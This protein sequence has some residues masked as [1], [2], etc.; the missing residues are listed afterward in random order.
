MNLIHYQAN[1]CISSSKWPIY[2]EALAEAFAEASA[3]TEPEALAFADAFAL[4][5]AEAEASACAEASAWAD[6]EPLIEPVAPGKEMLML[7]LHVSG[8]VPV[9]VP[10]RL[11]ETLELASPDPEPLTPAEPEPEMPE[12][13]EPEVE[14]PESVESEL[15]GA[16]EELAPRELVPDAPP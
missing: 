13:A 9:P 2:A 1:S 7:V 16:L 12:P 4:A 15:E 14:S 10:P 5:L 3:E 8:A 11:P 6:A